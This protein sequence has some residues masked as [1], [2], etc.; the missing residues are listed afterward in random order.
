MNARPRL[1]AAEREALRLRV[2]AVYSSEPDLSNQALAE[3]FGVSVR[4]VASWVADLRTP[5][6]PAPKLVVRV[7]IGCGATFF[8]DPYKARSFCGTDCHNRTA[9]WAGFRR[10]GGGR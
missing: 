2:R 7:C 8:G 9:S 4:T 5:K 3:R 10:A 1:P 6:A